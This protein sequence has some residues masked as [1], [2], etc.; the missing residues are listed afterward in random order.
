M[1]SFLYSP[2]WPL[3]FFL[4]LLVPV[5]LNFVAWKKDGKEYDDAAGLTM[6]VVII[7]AMTN[8]FDLFYPFPESKSLHPILDVVGGLSSLLA[9]RHERKAWK[10]FLT[11]LFA[12]QLVAHVIF[13]VALWLNPYAE[14]RLHYSL[15]LNVLFI[16]QVV[17]LSFPGGGYAARIVLPRVPDGPVVGYPVGHKTGEIR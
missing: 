9:Y 4:A 11:G 15:W 16:C 8:L 17:V 10:L 12:G 7:W 5:A 14:L 3:I 13:G 6:I 1:H 2:L